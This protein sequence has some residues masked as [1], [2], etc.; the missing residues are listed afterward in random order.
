M[1]NKKRDPVIIVWEKIAKFIRKTKFSDSVWRDPS[2]WMLISSNI[3]AM[4]MIMANNIPLW[5]VV[6]I[7]WF[8][9]II[10]GM[11]TFIRILCLN[12]FSTEGI[13]TS[14]GEPVLAT[15]GTKI[16]LGFVFLITFFGFHLLYLLV[17]QYDDMIWSGDMTRIVLILFANHLFS[18]IYSF[19]KQTTN[20]N[21]GD[22]VL[23]AIVRVLPIHLMLP[24]IIFGKIASIP[25]LVLRF[26]LDIC[27]HAFKH[28][29]FAHEEI[30]SED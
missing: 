20:Q 5:S 30:D 27:G 6:A 16:R 7:Y 13:T 29:D 9:N 3:F 11:F 10:I 21:I 23:V 24:F 19:R 26:F 17:P 15:I 12:D 25:F 14:N 4:G 8:Q 2:L 18:F 28:A 1:E 22:I